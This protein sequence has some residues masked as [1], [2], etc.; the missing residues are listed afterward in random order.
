MQVRHLMGDIRLVQQR[1]DIGQKHRI[2]AFHQLDHIVST[3]PRAPIAI[4][5][6]FYQRRLSS[7]FRSM[8]WRL[9]LAGRRRGAEIE[10]LQSAR[11]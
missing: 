3:S 5:I 6:N 11:R 8:P 10:S 7:P 4:C 1:V 2:V 9:R